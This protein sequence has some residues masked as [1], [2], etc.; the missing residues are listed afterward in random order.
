MPSTAQPTP[1]PSAQPPADAVDIFVNDARRS[2]SAGTSLLALLD[3][4]ALAEVLRLG[5]E[6]EWLDE[7]SD[8]V[9]LADLALDVGTT[10]EAQR[11]LEKGIQKKAVK[12]ADKV[13][14]L[15]KQAK[16]RATED[17]K[18]IGQPTPYCV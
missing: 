2:I 14:R 10:A 1:Q 9:K 15:L 16:D 6:H 13:E 4:M 8:Y 11:V 12:N 7:E 17:A 5:L 18:T 3:D